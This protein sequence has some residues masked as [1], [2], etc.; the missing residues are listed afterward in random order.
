[1]L[2]AFRHL[3]CNHLPGIRSETRPGQV[4]NAFRHLVCNHVKRLKH[5]RFAQVCSTPFGIWYVITHIVL[6]QNPV[7]FECS[8]P[9]G[10]WYVITFLL[11]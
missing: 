9:F 3:V 11:V 10:I 2:N 8:T 6:V 7:V 4:L 1:M 5:Q